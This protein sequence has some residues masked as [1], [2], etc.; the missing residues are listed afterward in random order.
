MP[1]HKSPTN[2][3]D[4]ERFSSDGSNDSFPKRRV[5]SKRRVA[6]EPLSKS[7]TRKSISFHEEGRAASINKGKHKSFDDR[8]PASSSSRQTTTHRKPPRR[9]IQEEKEDRSSS[10][11][12]T[13]KKHESDSVRQSQQQRPSSSSTPR[14]SKEDTE[15]AT[16]V[17]ENRALEAERATIE[18]YKRMYEAILQDP[19]NAFLFEGSSVAGT[20]DSS[21]SPGGDDAFDAA[22]NVEELIEGLKLKDLLHDSAT[23]VGS[24][25]SVSILSEIHKGERAGYRPRS[26]R[27]NTG[28]LRDS[29]VEEQKTK[30]VSR[31]SE[32]T[33]SM[34]SREEIKSRSK[35][36]Y[37]DGG[38][39]RPLSRKSGGLDSSLKS[40]ED[41]PRS[42]V[43]DSSLDTSDRSYDVNPQ[44]R[45]VEWVDSLVRSPTLPM[46]L[47]M[48]TMAW[49]KMMWCPI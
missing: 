44:Q 49:W 21:Q 14:T 10:T 25:E 45:R 4:S 5:M 18:K 9:Y 36:Q 11:T 20:M 3:T 8:V 47:M 17:A 41:R 23:A 39:R 24:S 48:I 29:K 1:P 2:L 28:S 19:S 32:L 13:T 37:D 22:L 16:L 40:Q 33:G 12:A 15:L 42:K 38:E 26:K 34:R 46:M 35:S 43:Q 6:I 31:K 7:A 30:V 27:V